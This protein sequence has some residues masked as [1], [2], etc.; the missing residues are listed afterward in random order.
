L[1]KAGITTAK[2]LKNK[3]EEELSQIKGL[4]P[5][6]FKEIQKALK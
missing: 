6:A 5:K 2:G 3:S 4:G 1:E